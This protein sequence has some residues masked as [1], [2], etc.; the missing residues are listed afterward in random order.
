MAT[1]AMNDLAAH[2]FELVNKELANTLDAARAQLEDYVDGRAGPDALTR[3]AEHLHAARGALKIVEIHG[4]ALLAEE[5][6]QTCRRLA[7]TSDEKA[8]EQAIEALTRAMVQ[9]PAYLERLLAGGKDV[10]LALLPLLNDLR[11]ARDKPSLS[12]GTL[13]L[14]NAG[15]F[16]RTL[17]ARPAGGA[18]AEVPRGFEKVAQRFRPAF[19]AALLGWIKGAEAPRFLDEL[20]RVCTNLERAAATEQVKQLWT[21]LA[22]VLGAI[23]GGGLEPSVT[24]K[25][26]IGQAD[27]QLKRLVDGGESAIVNAPPVELINNLLY[28]VAKATTHDARIEALRKQYNLSDVL[29]GQT[30]IE[31]AREGLAGPSVKLMRTVAQAIKE[32][33]GTVKDALDIFVRT[34]MQSPEKLGAQLDMLKKIGDTLGVLGLERARGQIQREAQELAAVVTGRA[35]EQNVLEKIAATLLDVE[36]ALDR[37]LVSAVQPGDDAEPPEAGNAGDSQQRQVTQ[38]VMGECTVNLAKVKE[39]VIQLVEN[40]ADTRPLEHVKPQLRG[41]AAGL[42]M[43]DKTKAV[44]V[45]ERVGTV[46]ATR[47]GVGVKLKPE[48]LERLADAIVS[49]EYYLETVSAGRADPWYMLDN[50]DRCLDLLESLPVVQPVAA[51]P[52]SAQPKD[53]PLPPAKKPQPPPSVMQVEEGRSDPE[54]VEV[55]IEEAKEEIASIRS[56]LPLWAAD[57]ANSEALI[58]TRRSF[59]T[60][61]GSG[62]MVGAQL[63]GEFAWSLENLLNKII[64][65]TL[66]PTPSMVEFVT[67][68]S[69]ALPEL[70]EQLETGLPPKLDV[71]LFMKQAEAFAEGDPDAANITSQSLRAAAP[72]APPPPSEPGMDPVLA[73]IFVKETRGHL[74]AIRDFLDGATP[75]TGTHSV[76]EPLYRACHTLLGSARMAG[77][78]PA[79]K[80]ATPLAEHLRRYFES[81]VGLDDSGLNALAAAGQR[82]LP[83]RR[84][85]ARSIPRS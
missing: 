81:G 23:R 14:L 6:E 42:L 34:G 17:G 27:R 77:Y 65:Q 57:R 16:E 48:Y 85:R 54:L 10:A 33:L 30:Q 15:P 53:A 46:I 7:E 3:T 19:Q 37:E 8:S 24:L 25:R 40:P 18:A 41:I 51:T 52:A 49:V 35:P 50:A 28:Y 59:H 79:M 45:V 9:L 69:A 44:S 66:E 47:L 62:R 13:V 55:F 11:Q 61:K 68:A 72:P 26:L 83:P 21:I 1:H 58:S 74:G 80:L 38:A 22:A 70:L 39:A 82:R 56:N 2:A 73:D 36:D 32:D 20:L 71:Q 12:E 84:L 67:E 31:Q 29:T 43:L 76:P 78:E 63:I 60:L 75:G 64:N 5:M 4:A